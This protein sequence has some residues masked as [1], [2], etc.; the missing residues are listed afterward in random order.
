MA[1]VSHIL[2]IKCTLIYEIQQLSGALFNILAHSSYVQSW[3]VILSRTKVSC[4]NIILIHCLAPYQEKLID[5]RIHCFM[6]AFLSNKSNYPD[7]FDATTVDMTLDDM[8]KLL[9]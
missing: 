9:I 1:F 4:N 3:L 5:D 7:S 8:C 2:L 6:T